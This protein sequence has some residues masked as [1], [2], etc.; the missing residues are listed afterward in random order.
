L[1]AFRWEYNQQRPHEALGMQIPQAC[2]AVS[3]RPFPTRVPEPEYGAAM[4]VRRVQQGGQFSWKHQ[5]VFLSETLAGER[6]ALRA[7]D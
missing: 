2:Y 5:E 6:I 3:T 4:W 7:L 1:I